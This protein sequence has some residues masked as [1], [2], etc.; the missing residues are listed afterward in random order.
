[1]PLSQQKCSSKVS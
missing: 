1:V